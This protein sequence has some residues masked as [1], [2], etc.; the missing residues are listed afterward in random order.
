MATTDQ[1]LSVV[2]DKL[3]GI[4]MKLDDARRETADIKQTLT[5]AQ[6]ELHNTKRELTNAESLLNRNQKHFTTGIHKRQSIIEKD[7]VDIKRDFATTSSR[8]NALEIVTHQIAKYKLFFTIYSR[9][10]T[11][12]ANLS[13]Y[14]AALIRMSESGDQ[15]CPVYIKIH[16]FSKLKE[17]KEMW[18]STPFYLHRGYKVRLCIDDNDQ[19]HLLILYLLECPCNNRCTCLLRGELKLVL[20]NQDDDDGGDRILVCEDCIVRGSHRVIFTTTF[21]ADVPADQFFRDDN[22]VI[23][24][25]FTHTQQRIMLVILYLF[26]LLIMIF[27]VT[28]SSLIKCLYNTCA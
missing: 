7:L 11:K 3:F 6:I 15:T 18:R 1:K 24:V 26:F 10:V 17:N 13:V 22:V 8:V 28:V 25:S 5:N 21:P 23:S 9:K 12:L 2:T 4:Q 16:G 14:R 27:V 20:V 19:G